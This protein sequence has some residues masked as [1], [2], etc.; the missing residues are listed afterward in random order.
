MGF[1]QYFT[2]QKS[3]PPRIATD[4]VVPLN[5]VDYL[6]DGTM[7]LVLRFDDVL[8]PERLRQS[9]SRLLEIGNWRKVGARVRQRNS[10]TGVAYEYHIPEKYTA[11]RPGYI[12]RVSTYSGSISQ[13]PVSARLPKQ[14]SGLSILS[15]TEGFESFGLQPGDPRRLADW[16]YTDLPPLF[17]HHIIF[18]DATIIAMSYPHTL[19]DGIGHGTF[20]RAWA[21]TLH[22]KEHEVPGLDESDDVRS[23]LTESTPA[24]NSVLNRYVLGKFQT[25]V[26]AARRL[27]ETLCHT[28]E[29][30]IVCIPGAFVQE[31]RAKALA[32]L[33][34]AEKVFISE[35]D[36]VLAWFASTILSVAGASKSRSLVL[37][38]SFDIRAVAL[39]SQA[40]CIH[41][42]ALPAYTVVPIREIQSLGSLAAQIRQSLVQQRVPEQIEACYNLMTTKLE[43]TG[44]PPIIAASDGFTILF[45]NW[46]K[47]GL[48]HLDFSPAVS[49][50]GV[51]LEQRSTKIG[52]PSSVVCSTPLSGIGTRSAG[53][54][55]GKDPQGN[56][57]VQ[58]CLRRREW[59]LLDELLCQIDDK[60]PPEAV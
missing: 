14:P 27:F 56:W 23:H 39:P 17:F 51:P 6:Y 5:K 55:L 48:F 31:L 47:A 54:C 34:P 2:S 1:K 24:Q 10:P 22:E 25:I 57:W 32:D 43:H 52:R 3:P 16:A 29:D 12:Y 20:L 53:C 30:R 18:D 37:M 60:R 46:E 8:D 7:E 36:V 33:N 11:E 15:S 28:Q 38:N 41:N 4:T 59:A 35:N 49:M 58:W 44:K 19:M 13:H 21:A 40:A 26:F 50:I 45:S 9:L 42:A